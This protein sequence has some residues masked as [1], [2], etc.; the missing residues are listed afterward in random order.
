MS[1]TN[2][3]DM[4]SIYYSYTIC[5][6]LRYFCFPV[7]WMGWWK[8]ASHDQP[9][10]EYS[11]SA[12]PTNYHF[13]TV[14]SVVLGCQCVDAVFFS[15]LDCKNRK[16]LDELMQQ[17]VSR[18]FP[19]SKHTTITAA[20]SLGL[21]GEEDKPGGGA[22]A[23]QPDSSPPCRQP[24]CLLHLS[25]L[26]GWVMPTGVAEGPEKSWGHRVSMKRLECQY[27][28]NTSENRHQ[29]SFCVS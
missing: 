16:P 19:A 23:G 18:S 7:K 1:F 24:A 15:W 4:Y 27:S 8:A 17:I 3:C 26:W 21:L 2:K 9:R 10:K 20:V 13:Q 6:Y 25:S 14:C 11:Q 12:L 22:T 28:S 5:F 29:W